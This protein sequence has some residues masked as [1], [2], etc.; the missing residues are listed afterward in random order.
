MC[1]VTI[2][3]SLI[4]FNALILCQYDCCNAHGTIRYYLSRV[5]AV[6]FGGTL[7]VILNNLILPWYV[8]VLA[9]CDSL[10]WVTADVQ[11]TPFFKK[12]LVREIVR[13]FLVFVSMWN[14]RCHWFPF[15]N[16]HRSWFQSF[17]NYFLVLCW[18]AWLSFYDM[19]KYFQISAD[20][21]FQLF[22]L[23]SWS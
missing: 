12:N 6:S 2:T 20:S 17:F 21:T 19:K 14:T 15:T 18:C 3:L 16:G 4:T 5:L 7:P 9:C 11:N 13:E 23:C 8:A 10:R 1:R 22:D